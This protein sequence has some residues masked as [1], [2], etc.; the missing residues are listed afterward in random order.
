MLNYSATDHF[1]ITREVNSPTAIKDSNAMKNT[2]KLAGILAMGALLQ[3]NISYALSP[4]NPTTDIL[5]DAGP[6]EPGSVESVEA[7]FTQARRQEEIQRNVATNAL[8]KL[9]L[10]V[11][12]D[13]DAMA[14]ANKA[15]MIAN[16]ERAA[17]H[18]VLYPQ[19]GTVLGLPFEAVESHLNALAQDYADYMVTHNYWD[20]GVPANISAPPFAGLDSYSRISEHPVIGGD[21]YQ[22]LP[23]AEN[24]YVT[25][26]SEASA[27]TPKTLIESAIYG[28]LYADQGSAWGHRM[29]MLLQDHILGGDSGFNND[30]GSAAS[31][32]F[33]GIGFAGRGDG[34]YSVF[35]GKA[36]PSQWNVVWLMMDPAPLESCGF[37]L[38]TSAQ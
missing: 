28:W 4:P 6:T 16:A 2:I 36:F 25:A 23:T 3:P 31:E 22:F 33:M 26:S 14:P 21:C 13:W 37:D 17:R 35:D 27:P 18:G 10:P 5:W 11:Q 1:F 9:E 34:S 19:H 38:Q 12:A 7:A 20:H 29:A 15:L 24:L 32:G 30:H 8:G